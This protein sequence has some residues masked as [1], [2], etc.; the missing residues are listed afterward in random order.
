MGSIPDYNPPQASTSTAI[1]LVSSQN[2][3]AASARDREKAE[4][5]GENRYRNFIRENLRL[6]TTAAS[7]PIKGRNVCI[8]RSNSTG[9][10][11]AG[12]ANPPNGRNRGLNLL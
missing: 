12:H 9:Y 1:Q 4:E 10:N 8:G 6:D 2:A 3:Q 7:S 5:G 11:S